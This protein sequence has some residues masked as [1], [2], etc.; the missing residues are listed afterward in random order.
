[1]TWEILLV[2][3]TGRAA[4]H[5]GAAKYGAV[6]GKGLGGSVSYSDI[7]AAVLQRVVESVTD[8]NDAILFARS[9]DGGSFSVWVLS[10]GET[11]KFYAHQP[12]ELVELLEGLSV[13]ALDE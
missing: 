6:A 10:G 8:A 2:S 12:S 7:D 4:K 11:A 3:N 9:R 1:M 13:A 5:S